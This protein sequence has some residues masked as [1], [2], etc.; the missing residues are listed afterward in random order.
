MYREFGCNS[1]RAEC[2]PEVEALLIAG[3]PA[4]NAWALGPRTQSGNTMLLSNPHILWTD[5][6]EKFF[7]AQIVAE[8]GVNFSGVTLV[9]MPSPVIGFDDNHG[10]TLTTN[11]ADVCDVYELVV[12]G[13]KYI[14]DG[15]PRAFD[16]STQ[17]IKIKQPDGVLAEETFTIRRTAHGPVFESVHGKTVAVRSNG[18]DVNPIAGLPEQ[19]WRMA[20]A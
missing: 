7:E 5:H 4:S 17:T 1:A 2:Y 12:Q 3:Q 10:F 20:R 9:G 6:M 8:N 14:L 15:Q 13:N 18:H 19:F 11:T 16:V